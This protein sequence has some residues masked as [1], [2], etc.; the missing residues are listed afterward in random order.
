MA[1]FVITD[2]CYILSDE[3]WNN[4]INSKG[5]LEELLVNELNKMSGANNSQVEPT[6]IGDWDNEMHSTNYSGK[7]IHSEFTADAGLVCVVEYTDKLEKQFDKDLFKYGNAALVETKGTARIDLITDHVNKTIV[8]IYD[9]GYLAFES[10]T[11]DDYDE[12]ENDDWFD[13]DNDENE[14]EDDE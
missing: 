13:D 8:E 12:D 6:L 4:C 10:Y 14:E 7:V 3:K 5:S 1:K 2:P 9:D 11:E